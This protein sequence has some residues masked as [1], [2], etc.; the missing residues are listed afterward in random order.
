MASGPNPSIPSS[1]G[2][3][4]TPSDA[5]PGP[6]PP[7]LQEKV[8][9]RE[10]K[11]GLRSIFGRS[12]AARHG[13]GQSEPR[14][15]KA[16]AEGRLPEAEA[17]PSTHYSLPYS[18]AVAIGHVPQP[19]PTTD[20]DP[21][22][23]PTS[24]TQDTTAERSRINQ[25]EIKGSKADVAPLE[26]PPLFK[27]YPQAVRYATL[28]AP[29]ASADSLI[30][31][32]EKK[33][34]G[35]TSTPT[36]QPR[37]RRR[38]RRSKSGPGNGDWTQ[39]VYIL[40]TSGCLLEYASDGPFDRPPQKVLRLSKTAAAFASDVIPGRHWVLHVSSAMGTDGVV[41][42][43]AESSRSLL[44]RLPFRGSQSVEKRITLN[45]LLVF[46]SA[47][48]M[49]GWLASLRRAIQALGGRKSVSETGKLKLQ[50]SA[51]LRE[52][53]S[54]RT[55]V[56]RDSVRFSHCSSH[57]EHPW[58]QDLGRRGSDVTFARS[59]PAREQSLDE[60]SVTN[61]FMSHDGQQLESLRNSQNRLSY[62][63][64][65]QRTV[66]TSTASSPGC[67]PT[68]DTFPTQTEDL[69]GRHLEVHGVDVKLRPNAAVI[70]DRRKSLQTPSPLAE[71]E[72]S[73]QNARPRSIYSGA[74]ML[75]DQASPTGQSLAP[76][77]SVPSNRR[78]S[79]NRILLP[80]SG[81][82]EPPLEEVDT[83]GRIMARKTPK[84]LR[85][86][87]PLSMVADQPSPK[88]GIPDRPRTG[89]GE[90][91]SRFNTRAESAATPTPAESHAGSRSRSASASASGS[92]NLMAQNALKQMGTQRS[93]RRLSSLG[94]LRQQRNDTLLEAPA[95]PDLNTTVQAG[96]SGQSLARTQALDRRYSSM[97]RYGRSDGFGGV[98]SRGALKRSSMVPFMS[99]G[100]VH[101]CETVDP[102]SLPL[103]APPPT[104]PLPPLPRLPVAQPKLNSKAQALFNR[105]SMP[106]LSEGPPSAPPP[107]CALPPLPK[108]STPE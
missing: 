65:G 90:Y 31:A 42:A 95:L 106:H 37:L 19:L 102:Q 80:E 49:D 59:D 85:I 41:V 97:G 6:P 105:R 44:S 83:T 92:P 77:F 58:E 98:T 1:T 76:N 11:L 64:S 12:R 45:M 100:G 94:A 20:E 25:A 29:V 82:L 60:M 71:G 22:V 81:Q 53:A 46:E 74:F 51:Q 40:T 72:M 67:S 52:Q 57:S 96:L 36:E 4:T 104:T 17:V 69:S 3:E 99:D 9:R 23:A 78:Y 56:I 28:P 88:E 62:V 14:R 55:L 103:P 79:T 18:K 70:L 107:T 10:S 16:P 50:G 13:D 108:A 86:S 61:S 75:P 73:M 26:A 15:F 63:S 89:H 68:V 66:I 47:R 93:P 7:I 24:A 43:Q 87:R 2:T 38:H 35:E 21:M 34:S 39:N 91:P 5:S 27:A 84:A 54:Q 8:N 101:P 33:G 32:S 48:E 30:K